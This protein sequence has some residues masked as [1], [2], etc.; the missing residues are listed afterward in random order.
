MVGDF[1]DHLFLRYIIMIKPTIHHDNTSGVIRFNTHL[2]K[3][4]IYTMC[5]M[6]HEA[7]FISYTAVNNLVVLPAQVSSVW[8]KYL[9][10]FLFGGKKVNADYRGNSFHCGKEIYVA[11]NVDAILRGDEY[12]WVALVDVPHDIRCV[13]VNLDVYDGKKHVRRLQIDTFFGRSRAINYE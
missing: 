4:V 3:P 11:E 7:F 10:A 9:Q 6:E 2:N 5:K 1:P 8:P 12:E 13:Y